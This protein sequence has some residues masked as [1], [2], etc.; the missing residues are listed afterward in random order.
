MNQTK[1]SKKAKFHNFWLKFDLALL[2]GILVLPL[3]FAEKFVAKEKR[4]NFWRRKAVWVIKTVLQ[5]N[6]IETSITGKQ[7]ISK[8]PCIYAS[9]H[10][11]CFDG[12]ILLTLLGPDV[13]LFTMPIENFPSVLKPWVRHMEAVDVVRDEVDKA[14]APK[15]QGPMKA[16]ETAIHHLKKGKS[17]LIF[18]EGHIESLHLVHY[19]HTGTAR[20][21]LGSHVPIIPI[22]IINAEKVFPSENDVI[23]GVITYSFGKPIEP[24]KRLSTKARFPA[25]QVLKLSDDLEHSIIDKLPLRYLPPYYLEPKTKKIGVFIDIDRTIYEGLSQKDLIAYLFWLNKIHYSDAMRVFYWLFMERLH[26]IQHRELMKKAM[27]VLKGWDVNDLSNTVHKSFNKR[28]VKN[29]QYGVLPLLKDHAEQNHS[30]V[31]VSEVIH[32]LA[33]EFKHFFGGRST[34]DTKLE[35]KHHCYTGKVDCL[36]Y[37][38]EKARLL[39]DFASRAHIDLDKSYAYADSGSDIPFLQ[40]V[41]HPTAINPDD[42]LLQYA[43]HQRINIL[44]D[45]S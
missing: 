23:P 8:K 27:L 42:R 13:V 44:E 28:L 38:E 10:P 45:A 36:C 32:P 31:F 33:Q 14:R 12:F 9:N 7:N 11:S 29:I 18:P 1:I 35:V 41:G 6:H 26:Q 19:F 40:L 43:Q 24:P 30:I 34:L 5:L 39:K 17:I 25:K 22:S 20:I 3:L 15:T 4:G 37:K 21:A 16:I 2:T